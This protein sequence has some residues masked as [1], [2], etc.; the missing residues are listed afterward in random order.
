MIS[1][2]KFQP[3][4]NRQERDSLVCEGGGGG[5][6]AARGNRMHA[7]S[8]HAHKCARFALKRE[9]P[10]PDRS[11]NERTTPKNLD[12]LSAAARNRGKYDSSQGFDRVEIIQLDIANSLDKV[13]LLV[14]SKIISSIPR[15][16]TL[17]AQAH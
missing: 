12:Y 14:Q 9:F 17:Q 3:N 4:T 5:G 13:F 1:Q 15:F 16:S 2:G 7:H 11:D 8:H 10:L 6:T